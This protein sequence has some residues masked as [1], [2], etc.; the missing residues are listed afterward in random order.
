MYG[1]LNW[2]N[3]GVLL[4]FAFLLAIWLVKPIGVSTQFVIA[5]GII[6]SFLSENLVKENP[7]TKSGYESTNSYLN[8]NGGKYAESVRNP[9]NY[10]FIFALSIIF[11]A[12]LSNITKGPKPTQ[13][14]MI[15]PKVWRERFNKNPTT[16]YV[17]AFVGGVLVLFGARLAGV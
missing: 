11:G 15:A 4:A 13:E 14:D 2:F 6:L 5:N 9:F 12:F 17:A 1:Q 7:Q 3:V 8:K 10:G 16:R